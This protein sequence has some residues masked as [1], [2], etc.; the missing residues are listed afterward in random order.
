MRSRWEVMGGLEV[1]EVW[2]VVAKVEIVVMVE[3]EGLKEMRRGQLVAKANLKM[4]VGGRSWWNAPKLVT[5]A[6]GL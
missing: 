2:E 3:I 6:R 1:G 5:L 4:E